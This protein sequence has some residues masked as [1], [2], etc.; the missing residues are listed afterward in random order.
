MSWRDVERG[1]EYCGKKLIFRDYLQSHRKRFC[2]HSCATR[3]MHSNKTAGTSK[4]CKGCG[5]MFSPKM[6]T[7][8]YCNAACMKLWTKRHSKM[9]GNWV[10]AM[11]RDGHKCKLCLSTSWLV[12][13][14]L[15]G[16]GEHESPNHTLDNLVVLCRGCH[17]RVHEFTYR[18]VNGMVVIDNPMTKLIGVMPVVFLEQVVTPTLQEIES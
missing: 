13:H 8:K 10:A 15:D 1:C 11:R 9:D 5:A 4:E 18:I 2:N 14:H 17:R 6:V 3:W 7:M 12:I 16:T